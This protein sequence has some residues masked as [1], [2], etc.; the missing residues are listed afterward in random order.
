[1]GL[2]ILPQRPETEVDAGYL[3]GGIR[4]GFTLVELLVYVAIL[5]VISI[6]IMRMMIEVQTSNITVLSQAENYANAELALRRVQVRLGGSDNVTVQNLRTSPN[7]QACLRLDSYDQ[8]ERAGFRFDGRNQFL[9]TSSATANVFQIVGASPRS[10]SVWVRVD[11]DQSGRGTVVM[12][13]SGLK[14]QFGLDVEMVQKSGQTVA[15]PVL[16][17]N[18][19]SMRPRNLQNLGDGDWHHIAVTFAASTTGE[20]NSNTTSMYIDGVAV[21]LDFV[22]CPARPGRQ[23][24]TSPSALYVGRSAGD[25]QSGF[26]GVVSDLRIWQRSLAPSDIRE[27]SNRDPAADQNNANLHIRLPLD[28]YSAGTVANSGSWSSGSTATLF[29]IRGVS[30]V[31]KTLADSAIYHSFCFLDL[32]NDNLFELWESASSKTVP[33]L[34]L[35]TVA[36]LN[37]LGWQGR[38]ADIFVPGQAGFFDVVGNAPETVIANFAV[39]KGILNHPDRLQ[40][41]ESK[42][43]AT[44]RLK[45]RLEFCAAVTTSTLAS[46]NCSFDSAF[47]AIDGYLPGLH[48]ELDMQYVN[49]LNL[50]KFRTAA[51]LPNMPRSVRATWYSESG[52]MKFN[53]PFPLKT[54]LWKRVIGQVLYRPGGLSSDKTVTFRFGVGG[55]PFFEGST[56]HMHDF[57]K[58]SVPLPFDNASIAAAAPSAQF[59]GMRSYLAAITSEAEQEHLEDVMKTS[60]SRVWQS[61]WIGGTVKQGQVF[62]WI[63][64]PQSTISEFW[65]G[66]GATGLPY[67]GVTGQLS[68]ASTISFLEFDHKPA[69]SGHRKRVVM[70]DRN[71]TPTARYRYTNWAAGTDTNTCDS[72]SG[73]SATQ[74]A[75]LC[76]PRITANGTAVAIHGHLGREGTWVSMPGT[77]ARCDPNQSHSTCGYYREFDSTGLPAGVILGEKLTVNMDRFREFCS[78]T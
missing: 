51:N 9:R 76:E 40:K 30:P 18:C 64:P 73:V 72:R 54:D 4:L 35:G 16:N 38:S 47:I 50:G 75:Q 46:A 70:Q 17:F 27:L 13:G 7:D 42:R 6:G 71:G 39:G 32:D 23:I 10:I 66:N 68:P 57:V 49:W 55:L 22:G 74:R 3:T 58:P 8:Y 11:P 41:T 34:P 60:V 20:A 62:E 45:K 25:R 65:R 21:P 61:G 26:K 69:V 19:A 77:T 12:W 59:C 78:G 43:L 52:V 1:M 37:A 15:E 31:F 44:T 67:D 56:Y 2:T 63:T 24:S 14:G 48:G 28:R 29:N 33:P 5:S 36:Q 53:S